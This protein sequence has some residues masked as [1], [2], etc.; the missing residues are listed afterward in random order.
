[1]CSCFLGDDWR[2]FAASVENVIERTEPGATR[3]LG[4]RFVTNTN[5][6]KVT[7]LLKSFVRRTSECFI[8][9]IPPKKDTSL[10]STCCAIYCYFFLFKKKKHPELPSRPR[11]VVYWM[12]KRS[13][14]TATFNIV[15]MCCYSEFKTGAPFEL[16]IDFCK[17]VP[18]VA[19]KI[20]FFLFFKIWSSY[21]SSG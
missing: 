18:M 4:I 7:A 21:S 20:F 14:L 3:N 17:F 5:F 2:N 10:I 19:S 1:M 11:S 16:K 12:C 8:H 9:S 6:T 15:Y 13:N